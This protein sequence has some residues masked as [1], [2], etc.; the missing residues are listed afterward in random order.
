MRDVIKVFTG[1]VFLFTAAAIVTPS[2]QSAPP[3][4]VE[5]RIKVMKEIGEHFKAI[6]KYVKG[7]PGT[8]AAMAKRAQRISELAKTIPALFPKGTGRG[9]VPDTATRALPEI[10]RDWAGFE[11][12]AK[13]LVVE[14][15]K[16][17]AV[18]AKDDIFDTADQFKA[19]NKK[20]CSACHK[21]FRGKKVKK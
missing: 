13:A 3:P 8:A 5:K 19:T 4:I 12:G 18:A 16:L 1:A 15:A 21:S 20:G 11:A 9:D 6:S 7:G 14:S 2:A 17:A 10:W